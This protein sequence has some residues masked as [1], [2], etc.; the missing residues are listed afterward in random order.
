MCKIILCGDLGYQLDPIEEGTLL[1]VDYIK[2][3]GF[4]HHHHDQDL[5]S[6]NDKTKKFKQTLRQLV[7]KNN[8]NLI[9]NFVRKNIPQSNI[10][11]TSVMR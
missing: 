7:D 8:K 11:Q 5:R 3:I 10:I 1:T 4:I 6:I 2:S 9:H